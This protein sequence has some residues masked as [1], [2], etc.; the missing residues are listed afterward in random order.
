MA[1]FA[2]IDENNIVLQVLV[3]D[4][5]EIDTGNWGD[6]ARW[7][8]TSYNTRGG[9]Y[10]IPNTDT[11]DPDQ[12]KAFRKNYAGI[13][14]TWLPNG[15]D[16]EGFAPPKPVA[17]PSF[18]FDSFSYLW[19]PPVPR[20]DDGKEYYWDEATL[21]WIEITPPVPVPLPSQP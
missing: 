16:G 4:Q 5:A 13:G 3:I 14:F 8:Q 9:V 11:P 6:P 15:P 10:Y 20:P 19:V 17:Y 18:V 7:I 21:S 1:H 12:S 2:Q